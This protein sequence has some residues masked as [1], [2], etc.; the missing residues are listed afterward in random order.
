MD[1]VDRRLNLVRTRLV[2]PQA[3]PHD[4]LA[5]G[6]QTQIPAAAVLVGQPHQVALRG[7]AAGPTRIDQQHE[8]EQPHDLQFVGHQLGQ[9]PSEAE[10]LSAEFLADQPLA[11]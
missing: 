4:R 5:F 11:M 7:G 10:G 3:V 1:G 8:R 6:D 2:A 9:E